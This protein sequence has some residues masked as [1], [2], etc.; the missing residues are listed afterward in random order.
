M[1]ADRFKAEVVNAK[2]ICPGRIGCIAEFARHSSTRVPANPKG[3][4]SELIKYLF[5]IIEK[6]CVSAAFKNEC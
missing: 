1:D 4:G 2:A 3:L 5:E 6:Q